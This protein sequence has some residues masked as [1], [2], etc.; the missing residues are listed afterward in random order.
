MVPADRHHGTSRQASW[1]HS[2]KVV[3]PPFPL[4]HNRPFSANT[5]RLNQLQA[6]E[7]VRVSD[8]VVVVRLTVCVYVCGVPLKMYTRVSVLCHWVHVCGVCALCGVSR[9]CVY[10]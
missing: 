3:G 4:G 10:V 9:V 1:H 6:C 2:P 5:L 7:Y 8:C